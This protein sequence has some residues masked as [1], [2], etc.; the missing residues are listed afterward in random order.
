[1]KDFIQNLNSLSWW[2]TVV[3]VGIIINLVSAYLKSRLDHYLSGISLQWR[4]WSQRR[5]DE[6]TSKINMLVEDHNEQVLFS[7]DILRDQILG[8]V[9]ILLGAVIIGFSAMVHQQLIQTI[10]SAI[11]A[12]CGLTGFKILF[13]SLSM[14]SILNEA[15]RLKTSKV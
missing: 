11:G 13:D 15:R 1:V 9:S 4:K 14:Y 6:R 12:L 2:M 10:S 8:S 5:Q 7:L 3:L